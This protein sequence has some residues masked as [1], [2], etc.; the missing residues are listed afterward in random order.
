MNQFFYFPLLGEASGLF[1]G[2]DQLSL[3]ADVKNATA[4]LDQLHLDPVIPAP[5][6][7]R[8]TGGLGTIVSLASI[9]YRYFHIRPPCRTRSHPN[10][11]FFP[12]GVEEDNLKGRDVT[13]ASSGS[14]PHRE[15]GQNRRNHCVAAIVTFAITFSRKYPA[16]SLALPLAHK[17]MKPISRAGSS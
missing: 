13:D 5:N 16:L 2:V 10:R 9:T 11:F 7:V 4:P 17:W 12:F 15:E 14:S 3:D 6:R 1:F 8:Q